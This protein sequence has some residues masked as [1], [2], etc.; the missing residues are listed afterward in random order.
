MSFFCLG[1][2][3]YNKPICS[4]LYSL[5]WAFIYI[6]VIQLS[7]SLYLTGYTS[8]LYKIFTPYSYTTPD[9]VITTSS[10]TNDSSGNPI[11]TTT[12][13]D[14]SGSTISSYKEVKLSPATI[15]YLIRLFGIFNFIFIFIFILAVIKIYML[16]IN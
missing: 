5:Y 11:T 9:S 4:I 7:A 15:K 13:T 16:L 1:N 3:D 10:I 2:S 8:R 6:I 14:V 12:T